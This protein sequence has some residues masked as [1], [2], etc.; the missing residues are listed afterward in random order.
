MCLGHGGDGILQAVLQ[1]RIDREDRTYCNGSK[2]RR[3]Q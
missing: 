2:R 3:D 1:I